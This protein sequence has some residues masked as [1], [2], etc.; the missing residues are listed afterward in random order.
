MK[1]FSEITNK[2]YDTVEELKKAEAA[3]EKQFDEKETEKVVKV[4]EETKPV[5]SERR[6]AA[7]K[8]DDAIAKISEVRKSVKAKKEE[9]DDKIM[10]VDEKYE[11]LFRELE[12]KK[13]AE[14]KELIAQEKALDKEV[15]A[16]YEV[17][18]KELAEFSKKYGAYHCSINAK[19]A[20]LFPLVWGFRE[21]ERLQNLFSGFFGNPWML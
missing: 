6:V 12:D 20:D 17:A 8:V 16:A 13:A 15:E 18:R 3:I 10:A 11:K 19:N 2:N 14:Q 4:K 5:E 21:A 7:K 9:L 1:Y